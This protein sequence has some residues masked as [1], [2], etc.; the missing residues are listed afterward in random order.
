M[1]LESFIQAMPKVELSI[2]LEGAFRRE[3]LGI[4]AEQNDI[5]DT[6]RHWQNWL[7]QLEKPEPNR[8][9][10]TIKVLSSWLRHPDDLTRIVYDLG[11]YLSR[12]NVKYA[13]VGINPVLFMLPGMVLEEFL[14]AL[15]DGRD[16]VLR[17]W[18]VQMAWLLMIP[19][20]EP[21]RADEIAR[22]ANS[23]TGKKGG[24]IGI[25]LTGREEAQP[26]AQ[27]ER[28][29]TS[30][31]KKELPSVVRAGDQQQ[32]EGILAALQTLNPNRILD[33][34]GAADAPDVLKQLSDT[35]ISLDVCL[36]RA[37]CLG[38]YQG[39][40][41]YPLRDLYDANV[42]L[43]IN[44]DMP[45]FYQSSLNDEYLAVV[46]HGGMT[47]EELET[48]ALN[49]IHNSFLPESDKLARL[50]EFKED[51]AHLREKHLAEASL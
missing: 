19:R 24:V 34:R 3:T 16:R 33:G 21:R 44:S 41:A 31:Q 46:Q 37:L 15:N 22:W 17:A 23:A 2:R 8:I 38:W 50:T 43:T 32:A 29:F 25:G 12:Q 39:Y 30:A 13:E 9:D 5:P 40:A 42:R 36:S 48:I 1:S 51:Y 49:A 6:V 14:E 47:I 27:F 10:E 11:V 35:G 26:S 20:E 7:K 18:N 4:I 28:A 45:T